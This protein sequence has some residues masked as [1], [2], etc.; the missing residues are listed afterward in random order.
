M[1]REAT[2]EGLKRRVKKPG[3]K[4]FRI[5]QPEKELRESE[6]KYRQLFNTASDAIVVTNAKTLQILDANE[7]CLKLYGYSRK[8]FLNLT[9]SQISAEPEK[10]KKAIKQT[11][12]G[13]ITW[14]PL[15]YHKKKDGTK[16]PVEISTG[17]MKLGDQ[18]VVFGS[19]RDISERKQKEEEL[20]ESE[21]K[22]RLLAE[23][24]PAIINITRGDEI[25]FANP[26]W[27]KISGH[28]RE[29]ISKTKFSEMVHPDMLEMVRKRG[30][31]RLRGEKLPSRYE[32]KILTKNRQVRWLDLSVVKFD[33]M[34]KPALLSSAFDITAR[35]RLANKIKKEK[36]E[37]EQRVRQALRESEAKYLKLFNT[38]PASIVLYD[39]ETKKFIDGNDAAFDLYGYSR[40]EFLN[41]TYWDIT[42]EPEKTKKAIPRVLSGE[43]NRIPLRYQKKKDG[44]VIPIDVSVGVF[45]L[46]NRNVICGVSTDIGEYLESQDKLKK[47][48]RELR[49]EIESRKKAEMALANRTE[50]L[51]E[52]NAAL[53][54]LVRKREEDR[55]LMEDRVLDNVKTRVTPYLAKAK[56]SMINEKAKFQL[57]II[58]SALEE[59]V[60]PF[61]HAL[62]TRYL[63]LTPT[64]IQVAIL[65]KEGNRTK[66]IAYIM[67][68]S[69]STIDTHR[70]KVRKKLGIVNKGE[71]LRT[72]LLTLQ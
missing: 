55:K 68:V 43:V 51:K 22:F 56:K 34:G 65:I 1:T 36:D 9:I 52:V 14:V 41:L 13:K 64:E 7:A 28:N 37:R 30:L 71:N 4:A 57:Q 6:E 46:D 31:A 23:S 44:T 18:T 17:K 54:V 26:A 66:E 16:F 11:I 50:H 63:K 5:E 15:R 38:V 58:E 47:I 27:E 21:T 29:E 25:L 70:N 72:R 42:A 61:V 49:K 62:S 67:G 2:S 8:E 45:M 12:D 48:N 32:L 19:M 10:S 39:A 3:N 60:S 69:P 33:Y 40:E 59:V 35:K 53:R 20:K 24:T